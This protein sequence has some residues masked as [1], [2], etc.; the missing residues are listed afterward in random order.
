MIKKKIVKSKIPKTRNNA[1]MTESAFWGWIRSGLRQKSRWWKPISEAKKKAQRAY[2]G[3]NKRRKWE[4][5]CAS[6]QKYYNGDEIQVDHII[7]VG[8]LK[9]SD[10]L[11]GFVERLFCEVDQLQVLCSSCHDKKSKIDIKKIRA[12]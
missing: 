10:D 2:K 12:K 1:T 7:P 8:T 6:C 4:Y 3:P 5:K 9:S 11:K